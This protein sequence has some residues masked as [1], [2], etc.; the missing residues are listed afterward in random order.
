MRGDPT[1]DVGGEAEL[2]GGIGLDEELVPQEARAGDEG[3]AGHVIEDVDF[4]ARKRGEAAAGSARQAIAVVHVD[5]VV[6]EAV[7]SEL[8]GIPAVEQAKAIRL[9]V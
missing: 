7:V 3:G 6:P 8:G 9:E 5:G 4:G 2:A 1:G